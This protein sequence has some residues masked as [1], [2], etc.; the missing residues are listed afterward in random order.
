VFGSVK[1]EEDF[2]RREHPW[3]PQTCNH[4]YEYSILF[5]ILFSHPLRSC[6]LLVWEQRINR[7]N[8]FYSSFFLMPMWCIRWFLVSIAIW[9]NRNVQSCQNLPPKITL[10]KFS[11]YVCEMLGIVGLLIGS[12]YYDRCYSDIFRP[13]TISA[14]FQWFCLH[15]FLLLVF[16]FR[17]S[18]LPRN[19]VDIFFMLQLVYTGHQGRVKKT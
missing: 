2:A 17:S 11:K 18:Y 19:W 16:S 10:H 9:T 5:L 8:V 13:C 14:S 3:V 15:L 6:Y 12:I 7:E 1:A 4:K